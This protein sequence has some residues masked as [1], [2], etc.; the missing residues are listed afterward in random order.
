M[1]P[2]VW[3][4][5]TAG[6]ET[7]SGEPLSNESLGNPPSTLSTASNAFSD[8]ELDWCEQ[9]RR[10]FCAGG[11]SRAASLPHAREAAKLSPSSCRK[12]GKEAPASG[13][14]APPFRCR[15]WESYECEDANSPLQPLHLKFKNRS[16]WI[17]CVW[18]HSCWQDCATR[19]SEKTESV[20][21]DLSENKAVRVHQDCNVILQ[22]PEYA[23]YSEASKSST[24]QRS[25][26]DQGRP[27]RFHAKLGVF[28]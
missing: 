27:N 11:T 18:L 2:T 16:V 21:E 22:R 8:E 26:G 14:P 6:W 20:V 19:C 4:D 7:T 24:K 23:V 3:K 1:H 10:L 12:L 28:S 15:Q 17:L 25:R 5:L 13:S 9:T